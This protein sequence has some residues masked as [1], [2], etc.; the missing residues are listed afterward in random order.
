MRRASSGAGPIDADS[1]DTVAGSEAAV[2]NE[3]QQRAVDIIRAMPQ[4][5]QRRPLPPFVIFGPPGTGLDI[6]TAQ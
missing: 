1:A 6:L 4:P 2:L 5:G 3:E